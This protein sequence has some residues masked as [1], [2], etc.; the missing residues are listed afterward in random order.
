MGSDGIAVVERLTEEVL[1]GNDLSAAE[2]L[3]ADDFIDHWAVPG[4]ADGR[5][6]LVGAVNRIRTAF[7]DLVVSAH[8]MF[9]EGEWVFERWTA[10]GTHQGPF[11]GLPATGQRVNMRGLSLSRVV[12][13]K[14]TENY[15]LVDEL[16]LL[17][18]LGPAAQRAVAHATATADDKQA[19][20]ANDMPATIPF[21][22][23]EEPSAAAP[24]AMTAPA[25]MPAAQPMGAVGAAPAAYQV[26]AAP[27]A[28]AAYALMTAPAAGV[29]VAMPQPMQEE[30]QA[31][32]DD[33]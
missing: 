4:E 22:T 24:E 12:D 25:N 30:G 5:A 7:P 16:S 9:G 19:T 33:E 27:G 18:Q 31:E 6:G 11:F 3:V 17:R 23:A 13:G 14:L 20:E 21:Q 2:E 8:E 28:P 10:E 1:N 32:A 26:A 29:P 15:G